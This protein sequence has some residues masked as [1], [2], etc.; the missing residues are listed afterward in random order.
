MAIRKTKIVQIREGTAFVNECFAKE[1]AENPNRSSF[2]PLQMSNF[3]ISDSGSFVKQRNSTEELVT[4]FSI[5]TAIPGLYSLLIHLN[6][7]FG[8]V[9]KYVGESK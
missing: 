7:T 6:K 4:I 8:I 9:T 2:R 1:V 3:I 5:V